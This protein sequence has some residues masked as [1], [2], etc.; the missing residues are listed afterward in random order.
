L[1]SWPEAALDGI[2]VLRT[3]AAARDLDSSEIDSSYKA[4]AQVERAFRAFNTDLGIRPIRLAPRAGG[5]PL[6][7][8]TPAASA[9]L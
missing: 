8:W 6:E 1:S 3:S 9:F 5:N 7:A 2:Y 4:L